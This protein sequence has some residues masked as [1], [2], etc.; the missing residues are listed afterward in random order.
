MITQL[1]LPKL[2]AEVARIKFTGGANVWR[3][4]LCHWNHSDKDKRVALEQL[5]ERIERQSD[6]CQTRKYIRANGAT[7]ALYYADGWQYDIV[8]DDN[9]DRYSTTCLCDRYFTYP[10][11]L[12]KM[13]AHIEQ[14]NGGAK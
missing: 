12:E 2:R 14:F 11:A 5:R 13:I 3:A 8:R 7:F 6:F 9:P 10:Q 1:P 4:S